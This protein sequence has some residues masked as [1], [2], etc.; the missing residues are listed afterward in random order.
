MAFSQSILRVLCG[1]AMLLACAEALHFDLQATARHERHGE[2]C[3][4]N[5]VSRDTLVMV[6]ST[7]SGHKGDGMQVNIHVRTSVVVWDWQLLTD[8]Y[9]DQ[10]CCGKRVRTCEGCCWGEEDG[11]YVAR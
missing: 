8:G 9:V 5:F 4:R 2:R 6:T 3:I 7:V 10:G 11:V 1:L